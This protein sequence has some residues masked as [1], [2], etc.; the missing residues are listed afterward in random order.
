MASEISQILEVSGIDLE[1]RAFTVIKVSFDKLFHI[2]AMRYH[3]LAGVDGS[4]RSRTRLLLNVLRM[5][6]CRCR[7]A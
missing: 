3:D 7:R 2:L 5:T 6:S 1:P 4:L